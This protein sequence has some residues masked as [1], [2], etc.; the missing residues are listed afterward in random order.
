MDNNTSYQIAY[1]IASKYVTYLKQNNNDIIKAIL[2]G[3]YA[4]G[5]F[6]N[7]SDIDLAIIFNKLDDKFKTQVKLLM[8]TTKF[9]TRI[10]PHPLEEK[11]LYDGNPF[12]SQILEY[13]IEII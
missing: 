5:N 13:G 12:G 8:L 6:N 1:N 3:S 11:D 9:D 4:R 7:D 10:E 2:F